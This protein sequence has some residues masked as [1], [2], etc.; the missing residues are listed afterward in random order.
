L[1]VVMQIADGE[2]GGVMMNEFPGNHSQT[3]RSGR[4]PGFISC[5]NTMTPS[6]HFLFR[7]THAGHDAD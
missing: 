7:Q 4:P 5:R 1:A 3:T 6:P 2:N